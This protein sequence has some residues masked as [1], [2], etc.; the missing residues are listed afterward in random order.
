MAETALLQ[1]APTELTTHR[2]SLKSLTGIRFFA[3]VYVVIFHT[4]VGQNLHDHGHYAAGNFFKSGFLAVP[5]FFI[6]SGFILAY[7]YE[8]QIETRADHFR[9]WEARIARIWP[10]YFISLLASSI[11]S[12]AFPPPLVAL[13]TLLMVQ[14]WNP[15]NQGMSGAWNLVCWTLSVEAFF[16]LVFPWAQVWL[17]RHSARA[18]LIWTAVMIAVCVATNSSFRSLGYPAHGL[19]VWIPFPILHLAEFFTGVGLGNFFLKRLALLT[20]RPDTR[21]LL[22]GG[23]LLTYLAAAATIALLCRPIGSSTSL[24]VAGFAAL[25]F[26]LAAERTLLSR[27]LSTR[28]AV[29]GGG[30]SYS[31]YLL[32]MPVKAWVNAVANHFG[33]GSITLRMGASSVLLIIVSLILFLAVE[34]P[35]RRLLRRIFA[36]IEQKRSAGLQQRRATS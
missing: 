36:A 5:L 34:N 13:A 1:A 31:M 35:A 24:C 21:P 19:F 26:C 2:R 6:L 7:T 22:P 10:A 32:Q 14:A 27:F 15:F 8:G 33:K 9:F 16:Y 29:L 28:A 12:F 20:M 18:Q 25:V 11:P 23:G 3:A 4:R 17:E 30:I